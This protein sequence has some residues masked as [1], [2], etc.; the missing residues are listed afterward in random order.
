LQYGVCELMKQ[1]T[2]IS[3]RK[4]YVRREF[5]N[6]SEKEHKFIGDGI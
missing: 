6:K 2:K 1:N 3:E 4:Q 5:G